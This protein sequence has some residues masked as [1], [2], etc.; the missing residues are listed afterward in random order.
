MKSPK[1]SA[2]SGRRGFSQRGSPA[3]GALL[4]GAASSGIGVF[5]PEGAHGNT[6]LYP[7]ARGPGPSRITDYWEELVL[8]TDF[9]K[10]GQITLDK[11]L[12]HDHGSAALPR[13]RP[14]RGDERAEDFSEV[15]SFDQTDRPSSEQGEPMKK[16]R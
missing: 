10:S 8:I 11:V 16:V 13:F 1:S 4:T 9:G 7:A 14:H 6:P 2:S 5:S 12:E 15:D 3:P